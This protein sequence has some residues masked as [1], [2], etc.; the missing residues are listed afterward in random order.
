MV[1][2]RNTP[3]ADPAVMACFGFVGLALA[4]HGVK[5]NI[6]GVNGDSDGG[7]GTRIGEGCFGVRCH[8]QCT[9][10]DVESSHKFGYMLVLREEQYRDAGVY[11]QYIHHETHDSTRSIDMVHPYSIVFG[12]T[13]GAIPGFIVVSIFVMCG[14]HLVLTFI[15]RK[16]SLDGRP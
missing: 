9:D 8:G 10:R 13:E 14:T 15:G 5:V 6:F 4:A 1:H 2:P 16:D 7:H 3:I 11:D 12:R